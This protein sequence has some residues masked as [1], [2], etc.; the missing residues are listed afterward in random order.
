MNKG[1]SIIEF[2]VATT[3]GALLVAT[4]GSVYLANKT[5]FRIQEGIAR[6]Q[7]N[8]RFVNY[9]L[10][11]EIRMAGFQGCGNNVDVNINNL[12]ANPGANLNTTVGISGYDGENNNFNP[13]LPTNLSNLAAP[14]N[15]ILEIRMAENANVQ[16][17]RNM[18][19]TNNPVQVYNR[20]NIQ[21]GEVVM[22]SDCVV[23]DIFVAGSNSNSTVITHTVSNNISND[24]SVAYTQ[25]SHVMRY[26]YSAFYLKDTGRSNANGDTILTLIEQDING[27]ER[28]LAEGVEQLQISYGVDTDG[29]FTANVYQDANTISTANNWDNVISVKLNIL[30]NSIENVATEPTPYQF[31][32][33]TYTPSD[34]L[35]RRELETY[36]TLRNRGL[37]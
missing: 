31:V 19:Q 12:V 24:L 16:L 21:A 35:L 18:N 13:A 27:N 29:D 17:D 6:M 11:H 30:F 25:G 20:L 1:F 3:L 5:N 4:V 7:E 34:R 22:I 28:E 10:N 33:T 37:P 2:M 36:I 14:N 15:D 9:Y 32:E 26:V 8:M 23:G